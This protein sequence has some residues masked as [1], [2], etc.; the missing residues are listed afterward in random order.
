MKQHPLLTAILLVMLC[1]STGCTDPKTP[2][3]EAVPGPSII[4]LEDIAASGSVLTIRDATGR[5]V[6]IPKNISHIL[7]DGPGCLRYLAY[8]ERLDYALTNSPAERYITRTGW[9]PY[10]VANPELR[11]LPSIQPPLYP[12]QIQS[13]SPRPDVIIIM[14]PS[15]PFSPDDLSRITQI[16]ILILHEGDLTESREELNYALRVLGLLTSNSDRANEVIRFFDKITDNLKNRV[17]TIP[18]FQYKSA[19][20]GAYAKGEPG[21]LYATTI[22]YVPF[23][24]VKV[25]GITDKNYPIDYSTDI[26]T[27][28]GVTIKRINPDAIFID[29]ST[30]AR[31]ENAIH[32]LETVPELEQLSAVKEGAVY[33]LLP[34]SIFGESHEADLINA[35]CVGK[36]IYPDKFIDVEPKTMGEYILT[37]LYGEPIFDDVN[38]DLG[39][40]ALTRIPVFT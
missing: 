36:A 33:G 25:S 35:Y 37:Y 8:L 32:E 40:L 26:Q 4:E 7:C 6:A 11:D 17:S 2:P 21:G 18:Q 38:K 39:N 10:L 34:T 12:A 27:V 5:E 15:G 19:Y 24:L 1:I 13:L 29:L 31:K 9:L 30:T 16:P 23:E 28:T 3:P 14:E 20:I 22:R